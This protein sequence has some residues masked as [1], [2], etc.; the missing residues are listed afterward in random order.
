[1][2]NEI[3]IFGKKVDDGGVVGLFYREHPDHKL[4]EQQLDRFEY[5]CVLHQTRLAEL[6]DDYPRLIVRWEDD[7]EEATVYLI[8]AGTVL[9]SQPR[10][11]VPSVTMRFTS[12]RAAESQMS[13]ERPKTLT[14]RYLEQQHQQ[15]SQPPQVM[16]PEEQEE[17]RLAGERRSYRQRTQLER[18]R[19][20]LSSPG[21]AEDRPKW[22]AAA[23]SIKA[24]NY[25][26][27]EEEGQ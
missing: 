4:D 13:Q 18:L 21:Q 7:D 15:A 3:M 25:M 16:S 12:V 24:A 17:E 8:P 11:A 1:M 6:L 20:F 2:A 22:R 5:F 14:R 27:P 26:P 10:S 19:L 23:M 9:I